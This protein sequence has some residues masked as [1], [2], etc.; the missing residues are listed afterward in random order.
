MKNALPPIGVVNNLCYQHANGI[1]AWHL[2]R[3]DEMKWCEIQ[4]GIRWPKLVDGKGWN[5]FDESVD[6]KMDDKVNEICGCKKW[7]KNPAISLFCT[8]TISLI[9]KFYI[10]FIRSSSTLVKHFIH[11]GYLDMA[12]FSSKLSFYR[13][14]ITFPSTSLH[15][16]GQGKTSYFTLGKWSHKRGKRI[17]LSYPRMGAKSGA[18]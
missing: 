9:H 14:N 8:S 3:V 13:L 12:T 16:P 4:N 10:Q 1:H 17:S 11:K 6:I 18:I 2:E 7:M 15:V 5:E